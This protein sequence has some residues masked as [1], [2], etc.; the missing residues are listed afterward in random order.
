MGP[1]MTSENEAFQRETFTIRA[2]LVDSKSL[3]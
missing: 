3:S 2:H 1:T